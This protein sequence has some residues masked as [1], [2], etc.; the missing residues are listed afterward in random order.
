MRFMNRQLTFRKSRFLSEK[1]L[2]NMF[3][4]AT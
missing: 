3:P 1:Q 4:T 2:I